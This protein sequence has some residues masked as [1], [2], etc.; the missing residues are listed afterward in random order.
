MT[1]LT[2]TTI[3]HDDPVSLD[4]SEPIRSDVVQRI[5]AEYREMPGL[6]LTLPQAV[7]LFGVNAHES[8]RVLS[9]LIECGFL[10]RDQNGAY[11]RRPCPRC[12]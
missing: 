3:I 8:Q 7:R 4:S 1:T 2:S 5:Q 11:W 10:R 9:E 12:S 6:K